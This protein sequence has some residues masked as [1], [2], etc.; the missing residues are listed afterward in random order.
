M[1]GDLLLSAG[2][3]IQGLPL[4]D[5]DKG[6]T[7]SKVAKEMKYQAVAIGNHEFDYGLEHMFNIEK[8][9]AGMPFLSANIVWNDKAVAEKVKTKDGK[10]AV[11]NEQVFTPYIIKTLESGI[12]V[13]IMGITTPDTQWTSNPKN[14]VHVTFLDPIDSGKKTVEE[15]KS[16]GVNFIIALTHLGVN[17][18]DT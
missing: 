11:K 12:K 10:L 16:K 9:T 15:L 3:L 4:S 17:R 2:D 18:P 8:Q 14:S 7:I 1:I 5:S 6:L 13:G